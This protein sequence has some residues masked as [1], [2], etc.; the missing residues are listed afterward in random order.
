M[1][2]M[3]DAVRRAN[4]VYTLDSFQSG[5][6]H[7]PP[8]LSSGI[9]GGCFDFYGFMDRPNSGTPEGRTVL[10]YTDHYFRAAHGR[11]VQ[12]A[13]AAIQAWCADGTLLNLMDCADYRQELDLLTGTL[14]ST[15]DLYGPTRVTAFASQDAPNLF[16]MRIERRPRGPDKRLI[17]RIACDTAAFHNVDLRTKAP[18]VD[19]SF[20]RRDGLVRVRSTTNCKATDWIVQCDGAEVQADGTA[21]SIRCDEPVCTLKVLVERDGCP[22]ED[23]LAS[24]WEELHAAHAA[25]WRR[26]WET[27]WADFPEERAQKVWTR[28]HYYVGSNFPTRPARPMCPTGVLSNIWGFYFPQ[29]VYYVAEN[30]PRLNHLERARMALQYWLDHLPDVQEYCERIIGVKGAYYPWT[31][32]YQDWA[33][34][35]KDGVCAADSYELHNSAY[36]VAMIWHHYL[37]TQDADFL[38]EF[39]PVLQEVFRYYRNISSKNASG[40]YDIYHERARGQD[41]HS[42]TEGRLTNLLCAGY[43]AE[44]C[45]RAF[46]RGAEITGLG[47]SELIASARDVVDCGYDRSGLLRPEGFYTTYVGDDRPLAS[48]KHPPQL[49][50][51]A[52]L[53]MPDMAAPGSPIETAW[54]RRYDLCAR[55]RRPHTNGWTYGEFFLSSVR[56]RAPD[57]AERDLWGVQP[58]RSADPRW[59]QFYESSFI[60][61]WHLRKSYYFTMSGLYLQAFTDTLVQDWRGYVD[62]FACLLPGWDEG[63]IAFHGVRARGGVI[64]SGE[65][66]K[67][68][69]TVR[70]DPDGA[71]SV[72]VRVSRPRVAVRA[73]GQAD[74][75]AEFPGNEVVEL[76]FDAARPITLAGCGEGP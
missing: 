61:G 17:V 72:S 41:E 75:P 37:L 1:A 33:E 16:A 6:P 66:R 59:I 70:L 63:E 55:A 67:G 3:E 5:W 58:C 53:P 65:W 50:P 24:S 32:P 21:L 13:L 30:V 49:N 35:E 74:G 4:V 8:F 20:E 62:L 11:H 18:G 27:C 48:Q 19:V 2:R 38:G 60:E 10:G 40:A 31:P 36:V 39:M 7:V 28:T 71:E 42:S 76:T 12:L 44:Y 73:S 15:Y 46:L 57:Q 34:Y 45:A 54:R 22:G 9:L 69:F 26:F 68:S 25:E 43:S 14:T 47:E 64:V 23:T 29:D 52:F 56:M 51:I